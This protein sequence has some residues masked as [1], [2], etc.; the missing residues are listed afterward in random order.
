MHLAGVFMG[1]GLAL[2]VAGAWF[3]F[4][5]SGPPVDA[6]VDSRR[7]TVQRFWRQVGPITWGIGVTLLVVGV[8]IWAFADVGYHGPI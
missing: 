4:R 3:W 5:A 8:L 7:S 6:D 2:F 1:L